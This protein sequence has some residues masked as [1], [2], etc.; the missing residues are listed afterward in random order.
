MTNDQATT[1]SLVPIAGWENA[2]SQDVRSKLGVFEVDKYCFSPSK[3]VCFLG[4]V[5]IV[6]YFSIMTYRW[7]I[8]I[9]IIIGFILI[10]SII[11]ISF[12]ILEGFFNRQYINGEIYRYWLEDTHN[13]VYR[14]TVLSS[15]WANFARDG[16]SMHFFNKSLRS[17]GDKVSA[18]IH[19]PWVKHPVAYVDDKDSQRKAFE[20][21]KVRI[22]APRL[23]GKILELRY[24]G[25]EHKSRRYEP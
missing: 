17:Y 12:A 10:G 21:L 7:V 13:Q 8:I 14:I 2:E 19:C 16:D 24:A 3:T 9:P 11:I 4:G 5:I 23:T 18:E 1:T 15:E 22:N 6:F 20:E 25:Q